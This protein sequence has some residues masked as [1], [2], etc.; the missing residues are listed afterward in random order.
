ML[1]Y[2]LFQITIIAITKII[3]KY[4]HVTIKIN[5]IIIFNSRKLLFL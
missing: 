1:D 5:I 2:I 4:K 3:N